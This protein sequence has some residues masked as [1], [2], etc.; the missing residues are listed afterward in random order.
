MDTILDALHL[1]RLR[2]ID[3]HTVKPA[4]LPED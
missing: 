3:V 4:I 1:L 2:E